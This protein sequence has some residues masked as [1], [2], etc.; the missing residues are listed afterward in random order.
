MPENKEP[1]ARLIC[2]GG[3]RVAPAANRKDP[4]PGLH[5]R[6][7]RHRPL[8]EFPRPAANGLHAHH[9]GLPRVIQVA[10]APLP[11]VDAWQTHDRKMG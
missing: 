8:S 7:L 10:G 5:G 6:Y 1:G 11:H 2:T 4:V 9:A 3:E